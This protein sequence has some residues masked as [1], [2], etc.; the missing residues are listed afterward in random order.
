ME[1]LAYIVICASIGWAGKDK[2]GGFWF[3]AVLSF[4]LT[5][6]V[7][8]LVFLFR[9]KKKDPVM[10]VTVRYGAKIN[11]KEAYSE[12]KE[13]LVYKDDNPDVKI[14]SLLD[15]Y[16]I[17]PLEF[18]YRSKKDAEERESKYRSIL[19]RDKNKGFAIKGNLGDGLTKYEIS[20]VN[21][22]DKGASEILKSSEEKELYRVVADLKFYWEDFNKYSLTKISE[23]YV[24]WYFELA[25]IIYDK[26]RLFKK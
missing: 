18:K 25:T 14:E 15:R 11:G 1:A 7:G 3:Y 23:G 6:I 22:F 13:I 26:N 16:E 4:L 12:P 9:K 17:R 19:K 24:M 5:P 10:K 20:F 2:K 21:E 8:V